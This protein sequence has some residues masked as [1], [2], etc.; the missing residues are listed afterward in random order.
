[1]QLA[2]RDHG[3]DRLAVRRSTGRALLLAG[4]TT[5]AGFASLAFSTN[6][7]LASLGRTCALGIALALLT[8][9]YLLPVWWGAAADR[10]GERNPR[11]QP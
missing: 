11:A 9:V 10:H 3:G 2:L 1:M 5:I 6:A 8:G 7:G 4:A